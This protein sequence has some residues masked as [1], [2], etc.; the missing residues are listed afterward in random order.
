MEALALALRSPEKA[1]VKSRRRAVTPVPPGPSHGRLGTSAADSLVRCGPVRTRSTLPSVTKV[2]RWNRTVLGCTANTIC[3]R[4][5]RHRVGPTPQCGQYIF[6]TTTGLLR[7]TLGRA[8]SSVW[9]SPR[10]AACPHPRDRFCASW[11][12]QRLV[13]ASQRFGEEGRVV[14]QVWLQLF[15]RSS[16]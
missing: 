3:D 13:T 5:Y 2:P 12:V 9:A 1:K 4:H 8:H 15:G 11:G 7:P 10:Q 16:S 6:A 14:V